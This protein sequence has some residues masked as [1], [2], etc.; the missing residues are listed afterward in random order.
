MEQNWAVFSVIFVASRRVVLSEML[1]T[2]NHKCMH[3]YT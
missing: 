3:F 1:L 2:I